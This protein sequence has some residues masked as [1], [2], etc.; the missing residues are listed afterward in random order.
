M[1]LLQTRVDEQTAR[2]F[3]KAARERGE[4]PYA[5]LQRVVR[6]VAAANEPDSWDQ[7]W[8]KQKALRLKPGAK[9]LADLHAEC[10]EP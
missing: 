1:T 6:E 9:T 2:R 4:T 8:E 10:D 5:C 3:E 7:H